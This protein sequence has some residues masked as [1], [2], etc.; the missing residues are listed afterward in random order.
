M[1]S[2]YNVE[3]ELSEELGPV[4]YPEEDLE[5]D[6]LFEYEPPSS[7]SDLPGGRQGNT[8]SLTT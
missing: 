1:S 5:F 3:G 7:S 2:F 4:S 6:Y 8:A